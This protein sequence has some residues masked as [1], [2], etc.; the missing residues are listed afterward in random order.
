VSQAELARIIGG[1]GGFVI[2]STVIAYRFFKTWSKKDLA[3]KER[4]RENR[5]KEPRG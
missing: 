3:I 4:E 2:I 5:R 1:L